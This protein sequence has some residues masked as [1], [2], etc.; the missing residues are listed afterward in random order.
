VGLAPK[1]LGRILRF[2]HVF[3][4]QQDDAANWAEIAV[5]CGYFDQS[6]L[7]RDFRQ[8]TG[9]C[10]SALNVSHDSLTELFM[11]KNRVTHSSK[12]LFQD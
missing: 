7:I 12:T 9:E 2:Q 1:T 4:A 6:H 3:K 5:A 8:F 11:R 10:P